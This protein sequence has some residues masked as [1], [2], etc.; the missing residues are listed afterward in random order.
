MDSFATAVPFASPPLPPQPQPQPEPEIA[1]FNPA[2]LRVTSPAGFEYAWIVDSDS[3]SAYDPDNEAA[4][5]C[6]SSLSLD[7]VPCPGGGEECG[8]PSCPSCGRAV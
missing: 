6:A 3:S 4:F 5:R 2:E 8:A 1:S 7:F